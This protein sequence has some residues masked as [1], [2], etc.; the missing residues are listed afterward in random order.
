MESLYFPSHKI[1]ILIKSEIIKTGLIVGKFAPFHS[2]H[3][4]LLSYAYAAM[5]QLVVLLYDA[6]ECT[7]VPLHARARWIQNTFPRAVVL[8]GHNS[9]PRGVWNEE[10]MRQHEEFIT[11]LVTPYGVTHVYSGEAY[12]KQLAAILGAEHVLTEKISGELPLSASILR[13]N[14]SLYKHFVQDDVYQDL[15]KY[16]EAVE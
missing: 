4:H 5:D 6:P 1:I 14:P 3:K 11:E 10:Y 16:G 12:G 8:E 15:V 9:P 13:K 7:K 2:G